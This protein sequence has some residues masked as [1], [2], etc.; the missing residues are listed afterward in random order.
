[1][2]ELTGLDGSKLLVSAGSIFRIRPA[3]PTEGADTVKVEYGGGY[4]FTKESVDDLFDRLA[5][6]L[7]LVKLTSR[8]GVHVHLNVGSITRVRKALAIN[9]PGTEI[10]VAGHYQH[11][12]ETVEE[13]TRLIA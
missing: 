7:R 6:Q 8:S 11:V 1:M 9:G 13:V 10:S 12:I 5:G 2:F 4:V 3:T